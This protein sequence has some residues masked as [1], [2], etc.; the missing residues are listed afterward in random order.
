MRI[1]YGLYRWC[2]AKEETTIIEARIAEMQSLLADRA[3]RFVAAKTAEHF[4][5]AEDM[6]D[7]QWLVAITKSHVEFAESTLQV[8]AAL[9]RE[10]QK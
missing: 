5:Q 10:G 1:L 2:E 3:A 9:L 4:V 7:D 6:S 8:L